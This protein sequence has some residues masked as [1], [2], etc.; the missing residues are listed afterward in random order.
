MAYLG[1]HLGD[2]A[3]STDPSSNVAGALFSNLLTS[4]SVS[5]SLDPLVQ[6]YTPTVEQILKDVA[7]T[8]G[9]WI[10]IGFGTLFLAGVASGLLTTKKRGSA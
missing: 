8:W 2:D 5:G 9:L 4:G 1:A 7:P 10:G 6:K 3:T